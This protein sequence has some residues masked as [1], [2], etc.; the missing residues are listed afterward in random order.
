MFSLLFD[1][2]QTL[3]GFSLLPARL[4]MMNLFMIKP[5]KE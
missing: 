4:V 2:K 5:E 1:G 3:M